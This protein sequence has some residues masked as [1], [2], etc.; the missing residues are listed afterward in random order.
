LGSRR[1]SVGTLEPLMGAIKKL[2]VRYYL[3]VTAE[4]TRFGQ[5]SFSFRAASRWRRA[6]SVMHKC[7][8]LVTELNCCVAVCWDTEREIE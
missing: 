7:S 4:G 5:Q 8:Y 1:E 6:S 2:G 3:R